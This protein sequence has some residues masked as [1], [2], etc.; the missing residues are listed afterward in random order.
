M[1]IKIGSHV[2]NNGKDMLYGSALEALSYN[3]NSFMVY[4]GAPQNS[5]RK[6][7]S[8]LKVNEFQE[9]LK[10]NN[11]DN[12]DV[13]V[14]CA[15][16]LN[17]AQPDNVKRQYAIDFVIKE[18]QGT[19]DIGA[20]YLVVHPGAHMKMGSTF[21]CDLIIDSLKQ[22][23]DKTKHLDTCICLETMAG[24]GTEC[25]S[26]FEEIKYILDKVNNERVKVCL[27]TCHIWDSGYD[28]VNDYENVIKHFDET[29]GLN[30]LK[31]IHVNDSKNIKGSHKDR[32]ENIGFGNIGFQTLCKFIY[33]ERF[34]NIVKILETPYV[35]VNDKV[36]LPPYKYEIEMLLNK[37]FDN[38]LINKI[39]QDCLK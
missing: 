37:E 2:S 13:I 10:K 17:L 33:D 1:K 29:I 12:N 3:A 28:I 23:L 18:L 24:K 26:T 31:V 19:F 36:S 14:H 34:E 15:Y 20:K 9:V 16:I 30:N 35:D 11:I 39:K 27:D 21:G 5:F 8:E 6:P 38:E 4:L 32:H 7:I 22:I 25:C